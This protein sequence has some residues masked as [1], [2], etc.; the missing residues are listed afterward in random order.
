MT[1]SVAEKV[2]IIGGG[3]SA[4]T[5]AFAL[6]DPSQQGRYDVT[7]YQIGWRLGGKGSSG[8]NR[9]NHDRIEEHGLHVWFGCYDNAF[10]VMEQC[11]AELD[12]PEG[13]PLQKWTDAF[14]GKD[15]TVFQEQV[16]GDWHPWRL[17]F[18]ENDLNPGSFPS[19]WGYIALIIEWMRRSISE[20]PGSSDVLSGDE[21]EA[22]HAHQHWWS[23]IL[24]G[25]GSGGVP[26]LQSKRL[27]VGH[28]MEQVFHLVD[29]L[30]SD[31]GRHKASHHH[32]LTF[33]I[34]ATVNA[35]WGRMRDHVATD[36][37]SRHRWI[38][39]NLGATC[40]KGILSDGLVSHGYDG[41]DGE[42]FRAWLFRH[43]SVRGEDAKRANDLAYWSPPV[44]ALYDASFAYAK[45]DT[46]APSLAAGT[47]L[48]MTLRLVLGYKGHM[49]YEMQAGMGDTVFAPFYEVLTRRGVTFKFF[50]QVKKL[51]LDDAGG[52][53]A[54]IRIHPQVALTG[55]SYEPL[56]DVKGLPCWPSRPLYEQ[57]DRGD[58]LEHMGY[59]LELYSQADLWPHHP[60]DFV[61]EAG[62]DFDH[63]VLGVTHA[64]LPYLCAELI[65]KSDAW[66]AM[67]HGTHT[68]PPIESVQ[69]QALQL[70]MIPTIEE[71]GW[72]ESPVVQG[73]YAEPYSS[74]ADFTHLLKRERW[75]DDVPG[76]LTY[77]CGVLVDK[78]G[79]TQPDADQRV[80]RNTSS[81][82][83]HNAG[84]MFPKGTQ[85]EHPDTLDWSKLYVEEALHGEERLRAQYLRANI[86]PVERYVL[87]VPGSQHLRLKAGESGFGRLVITG[88]WIDTG[89]NISAVE[90]AT[91]AGLQ[92]SRAIS[93]FP[94]DIPGEGDV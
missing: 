35:V 6:T 10:R 73:S 12:R 24:D 81:F 88:T 36:A 17:H 33:L 69:T 57:I 86:D 40:V 30:G 93:G 28:L 7:V 78:P 77:S 16:D 48:R 63:V 44:Q 53:I 47:S 32:L 61:L 74:I 22:I 59:N 43:R 49:V 2:T 90:T 23:P 72:D 92:A 62:R 8:R 54:R 67:I 15:Q 91:M 19:P 3:V 14:K 71:V 41:A 27:S 25:L 51:E 31:V 50:H 64:C 75:S 11:Y 26:P 38:F 37:D 21:H 13:A 80:W 79:E 45:G 68:S 34:D 60:G 76:N 46:N 84:P 58:E 29:D 20:W 89:L 4:M 87:S 55:D 94:K 1:D 56:Y 83:T 5:A 70:W 66:K 42:E 18:P 82:L 52:S 85:A 39:I 9:R 65:D